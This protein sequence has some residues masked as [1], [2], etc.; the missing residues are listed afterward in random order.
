MAACWF[1]V[2]REWGWVGGKGVVCHLCVCL[3]M[4]NKWQQKQELKQPTTNNNNKTGK[5]AKNGNKL[6]T[7]K[8]PA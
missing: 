2:V 6:Q 1:W 4:T 8:K 7:K 3:M 5:I